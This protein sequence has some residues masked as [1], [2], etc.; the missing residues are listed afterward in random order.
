MSDIQLTTVPRD[1]Y[2]HEVAYV[3]SLEAALKAIANGSIPDQPASAHGDELYWVKKHV[4]ELRRIA[5]NALTRTS[6]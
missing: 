2:Y 6:A 1:L 5:M 3:R 4:A